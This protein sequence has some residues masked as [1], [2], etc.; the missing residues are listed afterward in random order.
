M[1][2][3]LRLPYP[4]QDDP[5]ISRPGGGVSVIANLPDTWP[6]GRYMP[7][8][9]SVGS[10]TAIESRFYA[11][12]DKSQYDAAT[13]SASITIFRF[14]ADTSQLTSNQ[15]GLRRIA[16]PWADLARKYQQLRK[17]AS[18]IALVRSWLQEAQVKDPQETKD[19]REMK[20]GLDSARSSTRKL[21]P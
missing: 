11:L 21:F 15:P 20:A 6:T 17:N 13:A 7:S 16:R 5:N 18:A 8:Y 14:E 1:N 19:L 2:T 3:E 4:F 9:T 12:C 10:S